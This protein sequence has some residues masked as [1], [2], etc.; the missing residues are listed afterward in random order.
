MGLRTCWVQPVWGA[1]GWGS[2]RG[3]LL[4]LG[5]K[6]E[7]RVGGPAAWEDPQPGEATLL[8]WEGKI[9]PNSAPCPDLHLPCQLPG[10]CCFALAMRLQHN[11]K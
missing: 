11:C 8:L 4:S 10:S 3:W 5:Q 7:S 1:R 9:P 2:G 6:E